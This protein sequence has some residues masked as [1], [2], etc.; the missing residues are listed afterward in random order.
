MTEKDKLW[1]KVEKDFPC[2]PALQHV[3]YARLKLHEE[4]R[5]MSDQEFVRFIR[6]KAKGSIVGIEQWPGPIGTDHV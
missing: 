4:T 1:R 5:G 6:M 2:D 3:H